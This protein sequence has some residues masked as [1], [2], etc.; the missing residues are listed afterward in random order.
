MKIYFETYGCTMN[1]GDTEIMMGLVKNHKIVNK[2]QDSD[3]IIMNTCG[4]IEYT[5]RKI[6]KNT[7]K[8]QA[9]GKKVIISGCLPKI[10]KDAI[11]KTRPNA[12]ISARSLES[13]NNA[14]ETVTRNEQF[15][16]VTNNN[17]IKSNTTKKRTQ[18]PIA[19]V[20][21]SEGCL[22]RCSYCGTRFARGR[23][24]SFPLSSIVKETEKCVMQG[25]KE[26]Q[27]TAQDTG[28]YGMDNDERLPSLLKE[29][30][31]ISGDFRVRVGMMNPEH[32]LKIHDSLIEAMQDE[33]IYN[34]LHLPLQSGDDKILQDMN[35]EYIVKDFQRIVE[36]FRET[37][38]QLTFS[39]DIIVGYPTETEE[40]FQKTYKILEKTRPDVLNIKRY[41]PRPNT[42]A[43]KLKDMPDRI[44]KDRSRLLTRL[45]HEI[46]EKN[47][48]KFVG[49]E[50]RI[51]ITENGEKSM[52]ARTDAYKQVVLEKGELGEFKTVKIKDATASYLIAK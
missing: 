5:E 27:L 9:Q 8:Y 28:A 21:I 41:S 13:I 18:H 47:N 19:I 52:K 6:I 34:F 3:I 25:F 39:T 29:I 2:A 43:S 7:K 23:L 50:Y 33:K 1:Q 10:N 24:R 22:G 36:R 14:I 26:I 12:I 48:G 37:L 35:R 42:P 20:P 17:P 44:K 15:I 11:E 49:K 40:A 32:V 46:G 30:C 16:Q 38:D 45:H 51:L 31:K 4:V